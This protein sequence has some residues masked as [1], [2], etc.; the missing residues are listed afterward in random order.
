MNRSCQ[1]Y[2]YVLI[3]SKLSSINELITEM[4]LKALVVWVVL[5]ITVQTLSETDL[6]PSRAYCGLQH[7]DDY[8][9]DNPGISLDEFPWIAQLVYKDNTVKCAGSLINHRYVL[10]AAHCLISRYSRLTGIRLGD[11]DVTTDKDCVNGTRYGVECSDPVEEVGVEKLSAHP[12]YRPRSG[13]NDIGLIRLSR[14]INYS[15]FIRPICLPE[16]ANQD[17]K[18]GVRL[19]SCGWGLTTY[20]GETTKVKKKISAHLLPLDTCTILFNHSSKVITAN[21]LCVSEEL[22][23]FTCQGDSGG[24]LMLSVKNQWDGVGL[25]SF[26]YPCGTDY[27]AVYTKVSGYLDWIKQTIYK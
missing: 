16:A 20:E 6:L 25:V 1:G 10:T 12:G 24:P 14:E 21:H 9:R 8:V 26:G 7:S 4:S 13:E 2:Y 27:P 18:H 19:A 15:E 11:Y 22:E 5:D 17:L 3:N 23:G